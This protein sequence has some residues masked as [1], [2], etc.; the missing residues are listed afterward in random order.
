MTWDGTDFVR[1]RR[2]DQQIS[3]INIVQ[4]HSCISPRADRADIIDNQSHE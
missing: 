2:N 4:Q 1:V 3:L